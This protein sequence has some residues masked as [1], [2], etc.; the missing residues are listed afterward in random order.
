M[1]DNSA[2][3]MVR[4]LVD[5]REL[6]YRLAWRDVRVKYK[7][8]L[9]GIGWAIFVP[10]VQMV[11]FS[12]I[13]QKV[14]KVDTGGIPYPVFSY[15]GLVPWAL[16]AGGLQGAAT[17]LT[18]NRGLVTKIYFPREVCPIAKVLARLLDF[19]IAFVIVF[20]LMIYYG[21]PFRATILLMP[22][23]L[24]IQLTFTLGLGFILAIANLY[25]RDVQHIMGTLVRLWFF[26]S[27]VVYP[28]ETDNLLLQRVLDLNPMTPIL[29]SYRAVVL[30]GALPDMTT[31]WPAIAMA[32]VLF[33]GGWAVFH[34][35][36]F[37]FAD[38]I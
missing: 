33:F 25:Y 24:L 7:Q 12:V 9:I 5:Y 22:V 2:S 1:I 14:I 15:T 34:R 4:E 16:F 13:F 8:S 37:A 31:L 23:I 18:S 10:F 19:G 20:A 21:I 6:L 30:E 3:T 28:L 35:A 17:S 27:A 38:N 11:V 36:E 26:A 32:A 29:N